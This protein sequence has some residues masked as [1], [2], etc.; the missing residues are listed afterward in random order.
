[1]YLWFTL[2]CILFT[3]ISEEQAKVFMQAHR[4]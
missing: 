2:L 3:G 1:M 4:L